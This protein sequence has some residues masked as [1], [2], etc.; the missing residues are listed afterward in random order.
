M[1]SL[2]MDTATNR[3]SVAL[4]DDNQLLFSGFHDGATAHAEV[5]PKLV[6][7]ALNINNQI[8]EVVVGMGPGPFTGLRVGIIFAQTF[9]HARQIPWRGACSLDAMDVDSQSYIV[10]S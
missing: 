3:T 7:E 5:L 1:I 2:V 4:F 6:K 10:T 8:G 9:A